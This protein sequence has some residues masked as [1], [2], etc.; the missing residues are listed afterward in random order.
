MGQKQKGYPKTTGFYG[1]ITDQDFIKGIYHLQITSTD[2]ASILADYTAQTT[3][4]FDWR[5]GKSANNNA[6]YM[7]FVQNA[8]IRRLT[9][10]RDFNKGLQIWDAIFVTEEIVLTSVDGIADSFYVLP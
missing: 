2:I 3:R 8:K 9:P 6:H 4:V 5:I 1:G 10:T 7:D